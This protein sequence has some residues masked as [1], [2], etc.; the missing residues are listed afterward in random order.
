M[1]NSTVILIESNTTGTGAA[2]LR[3]FLFAGVEV[4]FLT[5]DPDRYDFLNDDRVCV[6]IIDTENF[7]I[8]LS[9]CRSKRNDCLL[10]GISS[11]SDF[12]ALTAARIADCLG[13]PGPDPEA[14]KS[15]RDKRLQ[16]QKLADAH[17]PTAAFASWDASKK[18]FA[19]LPKIPVVVKPQFGSGSIGV[20][21]CRTDTEL[22]THIEALTRDM[23][24]VRL[25]QLDRSVLIEQFIAGAE[26]SVE[27]FDCQVIGIVKKHT[28][29]PPF[30]I[31]T[32]HDFPALLPPD[33]IRRLEQLAIDAAHA[34][35]LRWGPVHVELIQE[36]I[37]GELFVI[38]VNPRLAGG[39]IP[40]LI[41][42]GSE[43]DLI[44][45]TALKV[46]GEQVEIPQ[47]KLTRHCAIR[48]IM[49]SNAGLLKKVAKLQEVAEFDLVTEVSVYR[50]PGTEIA[51]RHDY[52]DRLGHIIT[53]GNSTIEADQ[54]A[55][56]AMST[57]S[58][59][60]EDHTTDM[61]GDS[62]TPCTSGRQ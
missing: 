22:R 19:D 20:K 40:K 54:A 41:K 62:Q 25:N 26:Y 36:T 10:I 29:A 18:N 1:T 16:K 59:E 7:E 2:Y 9:K 27:I 31:E 57:I 28:T 17:I 21:L 8:L 51:I 60:I 56:L 14:V 33:T 61:C 47:I 3:E 38:E 37:S 44:R 55:E 46:M 58:V 32:G 48:F 42:L 15:A 5:S 30:F 50:M 52:R 39:W 45:T 34:L 23:G 49:P 35:N 4:I 13:L 6:E 12:Y 24:D 11:F 43:I 53:S